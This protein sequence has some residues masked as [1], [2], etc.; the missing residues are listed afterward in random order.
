MS[1][2]GCDPFAIK[3]VEDTTTTSATPVKRKKDV[4]S[5]DGSPPAAKV[6]KTE[7][8]TI[9]CAEVTSLELSKFQMMSMR[10]TQNPILSFRIGNKVYVLNEGTE[11]LQITKG[12]LVCAFGRGSFKHRKA[13]DTLSPDKELLYE[14]PN[15]DTEVLVNNVWTTVGKALAEKKKDIPTADLNYHELVPTEGENFSLKLKHQIVF[16]PNSQQQNQ[17]DE[18]GG[19]ASLQ[20]SAGAMIQFTKWSSKFTKIVWSCNWKAKRGSPMH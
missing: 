3:D 14:L 13:T 5:V 15:S 7:L 19:L 18:T 10:A 11:P 4:G 16:Q 1:R 20:A 2:V 12:A 9:P 17:E 8:T 6:Q